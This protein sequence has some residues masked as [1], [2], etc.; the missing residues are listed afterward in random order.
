MAGMVANQAESEI[1]N[2]LRRAWAGQF[3][4]GKSFDF[5][6]RLEALN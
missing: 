4:G 6:F 2:Y 1:A 3:D 5:A